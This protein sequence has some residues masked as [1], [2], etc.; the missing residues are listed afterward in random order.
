MAGMYWVKEAAP[1]RKAWAQDPEETS[2]A[3]DQLNE[4]DA[5][6]NQAYS[7]ASQCV[8]MGRVQQPVPGGQQCGQS[9][10]KILKGLL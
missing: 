10:C 1:S 5:E 3:G 2:G 6:M 9:P 7:F 8:Q 4:I